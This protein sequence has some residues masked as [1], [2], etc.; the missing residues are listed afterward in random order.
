[1][2]S[3]KDI[4]KQVGMSPSTISRVVNG[5]KY[6][7][8]EKR[9]Q[10]LNLI[11]TTGYVPNKAARSMVLKRSFTVGLVIPDTFNMF[12]RQLISMIERHLESFGYHILI[13]F[14][15]SDGS[16]DADCLNKIKAESLDGIIFL[17]ALQLPVITHYLDSEKI[18]CVACT[19]ESGDIPAIHVDEKQA[20]YDAVNLLINL[21]HKKI[22][23]ISA[24]SSSWATQRIDGY[25]NALKDAGIPLEKSKVV[26]T[27]SFTAEA[28]MNGMKALLSR[29][30]DFT[31]LFAI[32]DELAIGAM[33]A[34]YDKNI[35]VPSDVSVIGFD[36]IEISEYLEPRL[37]T[38]RQP[39]YEIAEQ[40]AFFMHHC[41]TLSASSIPHK[42]F[43]RHEL[44][45][46]E[47]T[48]SPAR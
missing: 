20:G 17:Q 19:V 44:I 34:L 14:A 23:L 37:T 43:V 15:A 46:R 16:N 4:A 39:I 33:R 25:Y 48:S 2:V 8:P 36:D 26:I 30:R 35:R 29:T 27:H 32:T 22:A 1:L 10:I 12:Q 3:I 7:N 18:P 45:V 31:A 9:E 42:G 47:S 21:G 41:I 40:T 13:F 5:K 38:I 28:G 24:N 6:V 11:E